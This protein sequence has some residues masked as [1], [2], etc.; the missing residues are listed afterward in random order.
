MSLYYK[1]I[2]DGM[3]VDAGISFLFVDNRGKLLYCDADQAQLL[4]GWRQDKLYHVPW[5]RPVNMPETIDY[6]EN[7]QAVIIEENEFNELIELLDDGEEVPEPA[8]EPEPEPE[9]APDSEP[10]P[11]HKMTVQEMRDKIA[12]LTALVMSDDEPF[13]ATKT[14]QKN[15]VIAN[16]SRVYLATQAIVKGE[17]VFPG[18]N[19]KETSVAEILTMLQGG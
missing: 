19:C 6:D 18:D 17:T 4:Q 5:L 15:D 3:A 9:P 1:I 13:T 7:V 2:S 12:E 14:Y 8:P 10:E 11:E 16:G